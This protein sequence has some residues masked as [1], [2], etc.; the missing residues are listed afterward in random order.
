MLKVKVMNVNMCEQNRSNEKYI[1]G[2]DI[3]YFFYHFTKHSSFVIQK[4]C[5]FQDSNKETHCNSSKEGGA[6]GILWKL[7][8][9]ASTF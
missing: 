8:P 9:L 5:V 3:G 2:D 7:P 6:G 1:G 4:D